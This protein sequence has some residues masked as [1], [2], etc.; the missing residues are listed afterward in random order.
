MSKSTKQQFPQH[1]LEMRGAFD[2]AKISKEMRKG[3]N[4]VSKPKPMDAK[5]VMKGRVKPI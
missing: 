3:K 5:K 1:L 4:P 2:K